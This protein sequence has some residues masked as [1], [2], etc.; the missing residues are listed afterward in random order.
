MNWGGGHKDKNKNKR[1]V[2]IG[3]RTND[4]KEKITTKTTVRTNKKER[5]AI[6]KILRTNDTKGDNMT[7]RARKKIEKKNKG[8]KG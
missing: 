4:N 1:I 8:Y 5:T 7:T 2:G 6:R 3:I